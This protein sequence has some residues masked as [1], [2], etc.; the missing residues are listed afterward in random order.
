[1]V[2]SLGPPWIDCEEC[3]MISPQSNGEIGKEDDVIKSHEYQNTDGYI[4]DSRPNADESLP[5]PRNKYDR[6]YSKQ[7]ANRQTENE[8]LSYV[9]DSLKPLLNIS[10]K[11]MFLMTVT[12][13]TKFQFSHVR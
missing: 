5:L 11:L 10:L 7:K 2:N 4:Q 12:D 8:L 1:M 13:L 3:K 6:I 9:T